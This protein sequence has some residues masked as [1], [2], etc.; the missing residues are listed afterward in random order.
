MR[1]SRRKFIA[2]VS[3]TGAVSLASSFPAPALVK[4]GAIKIGI[5][6]PKV[7]AA[8]TVGE[9]GLR[10]ALWAVERVNKAGGI[11]GRKV[12]LVIEQET[13]PQDTIQRLQRLVQEEQVDC[14]QGIVSTGNSMHVAPVAEK[15]KSLLILWDGTTQNGV[16]DT[17][18]DAR[19]VF[20][21]TD[22]ECEAVMAS[23]LTV[24]YY[25]GK[26]KKIAGMNSDYSYGRNTWEAFKQILTRYGVEFK[27][28]AELWPKIGV[29]PSELTP[30]VEKLVQAK[31]DIVFSAMS[32]ADLPDFMTQA[33]AKGLSKH[34]KYVLPEGAWQ[35]NLLKKEIVPEGTILGW[36]T[37][38]F[39]HPHASALQKEFVHYYFD[40]Y[41][42]APHS[43]ADRAYFAFSAYKAGV[44]A[45]YK[46]LGR[47]P[48]TEE[49][50]DLIPGRE[51]E[52][53]G[54][55]GRYRDD[56]IAEQMFYQGRTTNKNR[57]GF[58]TLSTVES[59]PANVLQKP[60]GDDF[61]DWIKTAPL[62]L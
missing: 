10:G 28:V 34:V 42:E 13:N 25:K 56:K 5:L 29:S 24:K 58:P 11:A 44:E 54:G 30:Y 12:E 19:Y 9:C 22:N 18:P 59:Y 33:H 3:A 50:I 7:G 32:F 6:S 23:L 14:V 53:L 43:E 4:N 55:K 40:R 47:W 52:G 35:I 26:F 61:W 38:Y 31:P 36:N 16:K 8:A 49:V 51:I 1:I 21:S 20:K 37:L 45:A 27:V 60:S 57:Y 39:N 2:G 46:K 17:M 15:M 41:K 48:S 62:P